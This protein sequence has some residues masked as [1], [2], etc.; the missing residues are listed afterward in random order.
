MTADL[1]IRHVNLATMTGEGLG[2]IE[3]AALT[4]TDGRISWIGPESAGI[5][6]ETEF[7]GQ[8]G[9]LLPGFV[10]CHTHLVYAGCRAH[11][12][13]ARL[14]GQSYQEICNAGGGILSTVRAS[15]ATSEQGLLETARQRAQDFVAQ[16]V[17][18]LDIKSGYGLDL[19]NE[20]KMLR[21]A[22]Q[23]GETVS[24]RVK[25]GL[26]AAHTLPPEFD[27][28][29]A[30]VDFVIGE[31]LPK[32]A[33]QG[34]ADYVDCFTESVGFTPD[35]TRRLFTAAQALGLPVRLHAD[36][37]SNL[38]GAG[39]AAEFGALSADHVEYT[40]EE[41]IQAMAKSGTVA[42]L[43]PT[44]YFFLRET[45]APP[46]GLFRKMGVPMAVSTDC[47]PGTSPS[48]NLLLA[49][50]MASTLFGLTTTESLRG[51][52]VNAAHA[53][54]LQNDIGTLEVGKAADLAL[55]RVEHP[56]QLVA[57][58]QSPPLVQSW[59]AGKPVHFSNSAN[60]SG[61]TQ[62]DVFPS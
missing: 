45:Q 12:Y 17:T 21:V 5:Q 57:R 52:T 62:T 18:T 19:E 55:W 7:D 16:G 58:I 28:K 35:Q 6:A 4:V 36:Q 24:V 54:G 25:T 49:M 30:Y 60:V 31:I 3:N 42:V 20:L 10:E 29:E 15:R 11:E 46:I 9:W 32:V 38:G 61:A 50:N 44:A 27:D 37:L 51:A 33:R 13:S 41:S 40:S 2:V 8:G 1:L 47:N 39:L 56:G 34:L 14:E 59:I 26:L 22:R 43:L 53:L 48:T 23:V